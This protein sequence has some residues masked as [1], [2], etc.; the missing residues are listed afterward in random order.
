MNN[1]GAVHASPRSSCRRPRRR[2]VFPEG[3]GAGAAQQLVGYPDDR[4]GL[5][6]AIGDN[7]PILYV[8]GIIKMNL[9]TSNGRG[10][11]SDICNTALTLKGDLY[12]NPKNIGAGD[13]SKVNSGFN[14]LA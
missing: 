14:L 13:A 10:L 5:D 11:V 2:T 1:C 3:S 4:L 8:G 7:Q 6:D 9:R 12:V